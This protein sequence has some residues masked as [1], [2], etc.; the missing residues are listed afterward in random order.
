MSQPERVP[1]LN[2]AEHAAYQAWVQENLGGIAPPVPSFREARQQVAELDRLIERREQ[3][4]KHAAS[5]RDREKIDAAIDALWKSRCE[6]ADLAG[7]GAY[8]GSPMGADANEP[9]GFPKCAY[10]GDRLSAHE[11]F[12]LG[13]VCPRCIARPRPHDQTTNGG[14]TVSNYD[15]TDTEPGIS[16]E[17][18]R[19]LWRE[20]AAALAAGETAA[21]DPAPDRPGPPKAEPIALSDHEIAVELLTRQTGSRE[22]AL[23]TLAF[24]PTA[25]SSMASAITR[26]RAELQQEADAATEAAWHESPEGRRVQA[27]SVAKARAEEKRVA[28]LARELLLDEGQNPPDLIASITDRE[29]IELAGLAET[30]PAAAGKSQLRPKTEAELAVAKLEQQWWTLA[31]YE[32]RDACQELGVDYQ[33]MQATKEASQTIY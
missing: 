11:A 13:R 1:G 17:R 25:T 10:C 31:P 22:K 21:D 8:I 2:A 14:N 6:W 9:P 24:E 30:E 3:R 12:A 20:E 33:A 23:E 5:Q 26:R 7:E 27:E 28:D 29:A 19:E 15:H 18:L 16:D 4:R 32:R